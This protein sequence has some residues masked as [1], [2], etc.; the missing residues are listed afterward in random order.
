MNRTM[1]WILCAVMAAAL[2]VMGVLGSGILRDSRSLVPRGDTRLAEN[3]QLILIVSEEQEQAA[4][5]ALTG[6]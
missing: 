5:R 6:R 2:A 4:A 1:K 3:D